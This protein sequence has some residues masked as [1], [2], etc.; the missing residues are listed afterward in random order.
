MAVVCG[1]HGC[2]SRETRDFID[3]TFTVVPSLPGRHSRLSRPVPAACDTGKRNN[4]F[5]LLLILCDILHRAVSDFNT[6]YMSAEMLEN[7][8]GN[9][10]FRWKCV[11]L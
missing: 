4:I 8:K 9:G 6:G 2:Y 7:V 1:R 11:V 5:S 3:E 10:R